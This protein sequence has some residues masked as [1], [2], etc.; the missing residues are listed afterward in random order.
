MRRA[1]CHGTL[2]CALATVLASAPAHAADRPKPGSVYRDG[3]SGRYLL[4]GTWHQRPDAA[5]VG[6]EQRFQRQRDLAGWTRTSVPS[7]SNAGVF[8]NESYLGTVHWYR[9]DFRLPRA[10]RLSKWVLR[11]ESVNYRAR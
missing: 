3:P 8:T 5:D 2:L 10:S 6:I 7:A 1:L 4:G 11:F 9:K